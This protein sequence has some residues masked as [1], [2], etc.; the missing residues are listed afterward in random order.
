[1]INLIKRVDKAI[2]G[3]FQSYKEVEAYISRFRE[4]DHGYGNAN[5]Y[6]SYKDNEGTQID[7]QSTLAN[8]EDDE[9]L[10]KIAVDIG[11]EI[12][13]LIFAIPEIKGILAS[14]HTSIIAT[15]V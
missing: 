1:M 3:E 6:I 15:P 12:P 7:L 14:L 2:W 4:E 8:I 9:I 11:V 5:F 10:F 13:D